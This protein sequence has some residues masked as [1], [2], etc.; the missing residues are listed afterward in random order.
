M[1]LNRI[2]LALTALILATTILTLTSCDK[3]DIYQPGINQVNFQSP[4]EN[5]QNYYLRYTG[6]CGSLTPTGDTLIFR[7]KTM[8]GSQLEIQEIFTPGSPSFYPEGYVYPATWSENFLDIDADFRVNSQLLFFF[9]SDSLK[10]Q[11]NPTL[12]LNQN[13]CI[14]WNGPDGF[15]GDA[16]ATVPSFKVGNINYGPKKVVSCVPVILDL[17][18]YL[19][20]DK[21]NL[22]SSFTSTEGGWFPTTNPQVNAYALI[23]V[24]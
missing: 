13:N 5:Q 9:G 2:F 3:D 11:M 22:Y 14:V 18:A 17:D 20:Y 12:H 24:E 15:A 8:Q 21:N 23:N 1:Q 16:I 6:E 19:V 4:A 7:I 10:L